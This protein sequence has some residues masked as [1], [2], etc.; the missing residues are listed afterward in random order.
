MILLLAIISRVFQLILVKLF[1]IIC[2]IIRG[3]AVLEFFLL[4]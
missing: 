4:S 3:D 2:T 1:Y